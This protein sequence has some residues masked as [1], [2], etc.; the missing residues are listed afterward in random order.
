[1]GL[2]PHLMPFKRAIA[3]SAFMPT[4]RLEMPFKL[5]L[6]PP[7]KATDLIVRLRGLQPGIQGP[8]TKEKAEPAR[9]QDAGK[10]DGGKH[11]KISFDGNSSGAFVF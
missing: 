8:Y 7:V 2:K 1:M 9:H 10:Q 6:Q 3:S 5:P 4:T 11:D